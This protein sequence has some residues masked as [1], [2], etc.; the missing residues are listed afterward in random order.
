MADPTTVTLHCDPK[1]K[2]RWLNSA[3]VSGLPFEQWAQD[4]LNAH[5]IDTAPEWAQGLSERATIVLLAA[6]I[7]SLEQLR[8]ALAQGF[9]IAPLPNAGRRVEAE[10]I[11]WL[12][13]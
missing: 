2:Q 4:A 10:V 5:S 8:E 1:D 3:R 6:G 13:R 7:H 11:Q 12:E 9:D